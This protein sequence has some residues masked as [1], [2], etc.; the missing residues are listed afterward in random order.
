MLNL[1]KKRDQLM[2]DNN[3]IYEDFSRVVKDDR[4]KQEALSKKCQV[5]LC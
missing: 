5:K 3:K 1:K 2:L 4:V